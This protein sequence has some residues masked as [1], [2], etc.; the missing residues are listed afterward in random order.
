MSL[1][2]T[3]NLGYTVRH[4]IDFARNVFLNYAQQKK[5]TEL[6]IQLGYNLISPDKSVSIMNSVE[7]GAAH[8]TT[9]ELDRYI[10]ELLAQLNLLPPIPKKPNAPE[11]LF[12]EFG[13]REI[14]IYFNAGKP[15]E[16]SVTNYKY[17]TDGGATFIDFGPP[18][19]ISPLTIKNISASPFTSLV[20][21]TPYTII[22]K[23]INSIGESGNSN[24][25]TI[26]PFAPP[27]PPKNISAQAGNKS[28]IV[29]FENGNTGGVSLLNYLYSTD[30]GKTFVE[31]NTPVTESPVTIT[32]ESSEGNL[33]LDNGTEYTIRLKAKTSLGI[34]D[35]S[36]SITAIPLSVPQ[37]P[38][39][40][41]TI[42]ETG[43]IILTVVFGDDGGLPITEI[44]YTTD[45]NAQSFISIPL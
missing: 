22:I 41:Y 36:D 20:N 31:F 44:E 30:D 11:I 15:V 2:N 40:E 4:N 9:Q 14:T 19:T 29:Y 17:S 8:T 45:P 39:V 24:S 32:K 28:V 3:Q 5:K 7:E 43:E 21:G 13:D 18:D 42:S 6:G 10:Y 35:P 1:N 12:G 26:T 33:L 25:I 34:S 27:E 23:A 38:H 16:E 37:E